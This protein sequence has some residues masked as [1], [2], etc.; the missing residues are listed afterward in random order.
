MGARRELAAGPRELLRAA[1]SALPVRPRRPLV[2]GLSGL[3]GSGKSSQAAA[4]KATLAELGVD[5][6]AEWSPLGGNLLLD[7]IAVPSK[8]LMRRVRFGPLAKA[9]GRVE[10]TGHVMSS[11]NDDSRRGAGRFLTT[12][13]GTLVI[14]LNLLAQRR[15][16]VRHGLA[17]RRVVVFDRHV[18]DS[19][20]RLRFLYAPAAESSLQR[21]LA[22]A[23]APKASIAYLLDVR[24]ETALARK[25][26]EW[27]LGQLQRQAE[28]YRDH[29]ERLGIRRL[30]GELPREQLCSNIATEVWRVLR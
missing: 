28:L 24:P 19:I 1:A 9:A 16:V 3:D 13:W 10:S 23:V 14:T 17:G 8:T 12:V 26:D 11:P 25:P 30:D 21:W 29:A 7:A 18:L 6:A 2:V 20:V 15:A 4:L 27:T 5:A 22:N